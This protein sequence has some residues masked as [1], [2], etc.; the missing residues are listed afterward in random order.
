MLSIIHYRTTPYHPAC[1]G[2][3]ERFN[4]N[5]KMLKKMCEERPTDW[6]RYIDALLFAYGETPHDSTGFAPFEPLY[7]CVV[8]GPIMVIK[9]LWT[10]RHAETETKSTYQY[11]IDLKDK[12]RQTCELTRGELRKSHE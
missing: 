5:L 12:L 3:V 1:S 9:E 8:R 7:G 11:V 4:G 6:D 2:L 10:N